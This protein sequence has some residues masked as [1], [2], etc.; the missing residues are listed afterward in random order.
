VSFPARHTNTQ[1]RLFP[2]VDQKIHQ[3]NNDASVGRLFAYFRLSRSRKS[4]AY[5][6]SAFSRAFISYQLIAR[7]VGEI[8]NF[9]QD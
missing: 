8:E 1:T 9:T 5:K 7:F 3:D 2:F 4:E 6:G